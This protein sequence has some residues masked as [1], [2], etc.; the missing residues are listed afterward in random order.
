MEVLELVETFLGKRVLARHAKLKSA[1]QQ[2]DKRS[3]A[4]P[5][6]VRTSEEEKQRIAAIVELSFAYKRETDAEERENILNTL[7]EIATN[8]RIELPIQNIEQWDDEL[9]AEDREYAKLRRRNDA[10]VDA[11]LKKY[12]SLKHRAGLRTQADVAKAAG[13]DRSQI[14]VLESG[15]HMPQQ[16]TLQKLAKAFGVDVTELM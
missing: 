12:S 15:K 16:K 1:L 13:F 11:F 3:G 4:R 5:T 9:T 8:Q 14:T 7:D 2:V 6:G 10:R